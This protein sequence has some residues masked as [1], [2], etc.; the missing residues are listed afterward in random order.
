MYILKWLNNLKF[1]I[2][3]S[4][5]VIFIFTMYSLCY[6]ISVYDLL[7]KNLYILF[8]RQNYCTY[9]RRRPYLIKMDFCV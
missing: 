3:R 9:K 6:K 1:F 4:H 8:V 2:I 7:Y 5:L